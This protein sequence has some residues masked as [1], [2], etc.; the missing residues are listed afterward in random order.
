MIEAKPS[1]D[2][3]S[4]ILVCLG[5]GCVSGKA[6]EIREAL[7]KAISELGLDGVNVD[8]TGCH[9][10]CQQGPIVVVEP[11]GIFYASGRVDDAPAIVQSHL[12]DAQPVDRL[13]F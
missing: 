5:T 7:E 12:R 2:N 3:Q 8:F 6:F 9:G 10:F 11:A 1:K 13:F 4:T